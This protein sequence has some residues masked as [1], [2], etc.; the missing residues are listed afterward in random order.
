M[1][2]TYIY[3]KAEYHYET[4]ELHNLPRSHASN[5]TLPILRWFIDNDLMSD[6][7]LSTCSDEIAEYRRGK[8]SLQ[9][10]Y[11]WWDECLAGEMVSNEGNAFGQEY[12]DFSKGRYI[13]DYVELLQGSLPSEFHVKYDDA[14]YSV[15]K[16]RI[17]ERYREWKKRNRP[18][19]RFWRSN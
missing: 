10:L 7:F 3:D 11:S 6:F 13:S 9:D 5:H 18:W 16:K 15:L 1:S 4:V 8:M 14:N 12:F 19:W 17:D 2:S